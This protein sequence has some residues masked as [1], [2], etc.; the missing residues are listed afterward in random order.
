MRRQDSA[1]DVRGVSLSKMEIGKPSKDGIDLTVLGVCTGTGLLHLDCALVRFGQESP[2]A[3]LR[4]K[5]QQVSTYC[6][7][8][9]YRQL[10]VCTVR[11]DTYPPI[12]ERWSHQSSTSWRPRQIQAST[13][14]R[15]PGRQ[16]VF[17]RHHDLL[18]QTWHRTVIHRPCGHSQRGFKII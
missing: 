6:T 17:G 5:L 15:R 10:I 16:F 13:T 4:V 3:P 11:F 8:T 12:S 2:S 1:T 14:P 9:P 18:P 7:L